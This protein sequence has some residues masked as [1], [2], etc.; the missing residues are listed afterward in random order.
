MIASSAPTHR[1]SFTWIATI[2][3]M[4]SVDRGMAVSSIHAGRWRV[5]FEA[6]GAGEPVILV[7]SSVSG[8]QQWRSLT[9]ELASR[10]QVVAVDLF[11]YG[12][13]S[14]WPPTQPQTLAGQG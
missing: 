9:G 14:S 13:S 5:G 8:R 12:E 10:F 6:S 11:G 7:H 3:G 1:S 2:G 4:G